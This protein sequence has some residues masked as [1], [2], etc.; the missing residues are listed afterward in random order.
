MA[1]ERAQRVRKVNIPLSEEVHTKAKIISALK[2]V[3]LSEYFQKAVE[4]AVKKDKKILEGL[5]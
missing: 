2:R 5:K 4:E 3:T 1:E